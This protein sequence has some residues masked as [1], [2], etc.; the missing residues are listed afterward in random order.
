MA[1]PHQM[2]YNQRLMRTSIH[3]EWTVWCDMPRS[4]GVMFIA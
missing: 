3:G 1:V 2:P 4:Q